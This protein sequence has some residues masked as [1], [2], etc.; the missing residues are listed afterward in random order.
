MRRLFL[1]E[2]VV[3][4]YAFSAFLTIPL[5]Q[6][7]VYRRI[8]EQVTNTSYPVSDNTSSTCGANG[9]SNHSIYTEEVQRRASLFA[10]YTDAFSVVPSLVVT[11]VLVAYSDRGGRRIAIVCPLI[12]TLLYTLAFLVVSYFKLNIYLLIGSS[13]VN[14]LFGGM[15]AFM[16]G[17]FAY[18]TD[19]C[20]GERQKTLRIAGVDM[21]IGLLS[22]AASLST[23]Y[24]LRAAGFNWPLV[25]SVL[26]QCVVLLYVI[27]I[28]EET[29]T[30]AP[31]DA[32]DLDGSARSSVLKHIIF[33]IYEMF[34]GAT[35]RSRTR[36]ALLLLIITSLVFALFGGS[37][38]LT[39]FE[40]SEPLCWNAVLIGYG[41]ALS[42]TLFLASFLGL[43]AFM[44]CGVPQLLIILIGMLSVLSSMVLLAFTK[45]TLLMFIARAAVL[46]AVMPFPVLRSMMS[47]IISKSEQGAL[48]ACISFLENLSLSAS[49]A[50]FN[51]VYSATVAWYPGFVF[52]LSAGLCAIPLFALGV[53]ALIGVDVAQKEE[54][55]EPA[56]SGEEEPVPNER[57]SSPL[58]S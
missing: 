30:K 20:T 22:G 37:S 36:L 10:L 21:M 39:L 44:Y 18:V 52:A 32:V 14:S 26:C 5:L 31:A 12:G 51:S 38:V 25:T 45:T 2:P 6:Q 28:L 17:C 3:A 48:F 34:A 11:L 50:V 46:L 8:W 42:S 53:V 33:G 7:Y 40:L 24:F 27:F 57:D 55:P 41:A 13:I 19:L 49:G 54:V 43:S 29:V 23:G 56:I 1:V 35:R 16:G 58:V 15:G 9:S 47:N 4:V